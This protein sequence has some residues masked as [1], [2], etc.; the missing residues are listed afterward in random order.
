VKFSEVAIAEV[1]FSHPDHLSRAEK[2]QSLIEGVLQHVLG[3]N[4]EIRYKLVPCTA[5]KDPRLKRHS[6]SLL[7]CSGPMK[8]KL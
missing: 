5:R 7:G 6:F 3:F 4:V 1:G 2:M 8:M